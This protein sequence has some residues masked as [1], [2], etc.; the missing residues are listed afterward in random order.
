MKKIILFVSVLLLSGLISFSQD[1]QFSPAV[2]SSGGGSHSIG[3]VTISRWRIG[4]INVITLPS[5]ENAQKMATVTNTI[6]P[7]D[8]PSVW[9][10]TLFPN[11]VQGKLNVRFD[12]ANKGEF[13]I[14]LFDVTGRKMMTGEAVIIFP[15]QIIE[16]DLSGLTP[17]LYV[18]K[19]IPSG[20]GNHKQFKITK[21]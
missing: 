17:A 16:L 1:V 20:E 3:A 19:I 2:I 12:L 14:E 8:S 7:V 6:L 9:T 11:P 13:A 4:Q 10:V 5:E 18:L 15:G 21:Q